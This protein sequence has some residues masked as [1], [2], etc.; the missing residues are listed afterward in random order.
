MGGGRVDVRPQS[1]ARM[2]AHTEHNHVP[3]TRSSS[4]SSMYRESRPVP[5]P[6]PKSIF[7]TPAAVVAAAADE[8]EEE[9]TARLPHP[10]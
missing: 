4:N 10:P 7:P 3:S 1:Y 8:E 2:H 6:T 5:V 9:E